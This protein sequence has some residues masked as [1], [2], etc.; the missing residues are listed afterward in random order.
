MAKLEPSFYLQEDV[1]ST[2]KSLLGKILYTQIDGE[3]TAGIISETEA[4]HESEKAC[5]AYNRRRTK[6]TELLF[7]KGGVCYIYLCYGIHHLFNVVT[8][9][10]E[11]AQAVLIRGLNPYKGIDVMLERRKMAKQK[12]NLSS[13]PGTLSQALGLRTDLNGTSLQS[14]TVWIEDQGIEIQKNQFEISPRIGVD[15]AGNDA[16][17]PWRFVLNKLFNQS[18]FFR[19][20]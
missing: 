10:N 14:D 8:G 19:K 4:Y 11:E 6:R 3:I 15:Y 12:P 9:P 17:L 16:Q 18:D 5:H 7:N 20:T 2:A 1:V 13:G